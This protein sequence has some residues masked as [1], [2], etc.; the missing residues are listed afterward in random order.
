[1]N[2]CNFLILRRGTALEWLKVWTQSVARQQDLG[3]VTFYF[4]RN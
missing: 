3:C 2:S 4:G 1:M